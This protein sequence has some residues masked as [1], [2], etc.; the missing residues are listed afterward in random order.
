MSDLKQIPFFGVAVNPQ[1]YLNIFYLLL[2][3]PLGIAY[4]V[5]LV[6]GISLG[7][8]LAIIWVGIPILVIVLAAAWALSQLERILAIGLLHED[9]PDI[10]SREDRS[11]QLE[12]GLGLEERVFISLWRRLKAH[13]SDRL[14][15]TGIV[16]LFL[17]FPMGIASFVI[18][19]TSVAVSVSFIGAPFYYSRI[20][21]AIDLGFW[22]VD[23]L[24]EAL[25]LSL[26]GIV[27]AF[28]SLHIMN[29]AAFLSGRLARLMLGKL[30]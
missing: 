22:Q 1:S 25:V 19:V 16:Y 20:D 7:V 26:V 11:K 18:V 12:E 14:T 4:F 23:E 30:H 8:G 27:A 24:W 9:I 13:L 15:W 6:T 10:A 5:F 3:F 17:K 2:S 21:E 29:G 28:V